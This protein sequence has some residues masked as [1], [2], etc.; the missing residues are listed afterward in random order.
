MA[1]RAA[2][3]NSSCGEPSSGAARKNKLTASPCVIAEIHG[4]S[5]SYVCVIAQGTTS[6]PRS[7]S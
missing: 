4:G 2:A 6:Q 1:A 5:S 3:E 7:S